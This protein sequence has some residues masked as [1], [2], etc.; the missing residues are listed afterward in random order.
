[1][2]QECTFCGH[3]AY[4]KVV[5]VCGRCGRP[6]APSCPPTDSEMLDWL[7]R[8]ARTIADPYAGTCFQDREHIASAMSAEKGKE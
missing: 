1:M 4:G 6:L 5:K 8:S 3:I 2:E 7:L